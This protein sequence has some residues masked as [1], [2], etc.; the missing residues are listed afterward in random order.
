MEVPYTRYYPCARTQS[1]GSQPSNDALS[2]PPTTIFFFLLSPFHTSCA[3]LPSVGGKRPHLTRWLI[4]QP[5]S[6]CLLARFFGVYLNRN[7]NAWRSVH[8]PRFHLIITLTLADRRDPRATY[9]PCNIWWHVAAESSESS[10]S[11]QK[12]LFSMEA[13]RKALSYCGGATNSCPGS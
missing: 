1:F 6:D 13:A 10:E 5:S 2:L 11:L 7:V 8:S 3:I 12:R 4:E 9:S